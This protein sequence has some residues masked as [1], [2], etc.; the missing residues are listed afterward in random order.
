MGLGSKNGRRKIMEAKEERVRDG[1][2]GRRRDKENLSE[3]G[4][5]TKKRRMNRGGGRERR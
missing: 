3:K 4:V 1:K 2:P 5:E